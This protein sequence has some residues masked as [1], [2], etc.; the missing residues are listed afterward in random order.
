MVHSMGAHEDPL[1]SLA[2]VIDSCYSHGCSLTG[3][4]TGTL[5]LS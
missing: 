1:R 3:P 4:M 5:L 2:L